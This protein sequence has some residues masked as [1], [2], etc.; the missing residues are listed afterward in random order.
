MVPVTI[1]KM[2]SLESKLSPF[3]R[4]IKDEKNYSAYNQYTNFTSEVNET[5]KSENQR[6]IDQR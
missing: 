2:K 1:A 4:I 3:K 5:S 6:E